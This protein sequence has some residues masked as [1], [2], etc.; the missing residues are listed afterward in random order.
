MKPETRDAIGV[1]VA[2]VI[3]ASP[4]LIVLASYLFEGRFW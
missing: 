3:G 1:V 4:A 2:V